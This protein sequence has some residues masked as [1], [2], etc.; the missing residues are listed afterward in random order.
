MPLQDR[1]ERMSEPEADAIHGR[2]AG[3]ERRMMHQDDDG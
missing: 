2:N 3:Q 1:L